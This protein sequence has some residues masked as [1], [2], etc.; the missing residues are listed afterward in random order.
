MIRAV[1][2]L[3]EVNSCSFVQPVHILH[4]VVTLG[5]FR[6]RKKKQ[7]SICFQAAWTVHCF[8]PVSHFF[9]ARQIGAFPFPLRL[10]Y[11]Q[12]LCGLY[13]AM[14]H[15]PFIIYLL[16]E[17]QMGSNRHFRIIRRIG[18]TEKCFRSSVE[19]SIKERLVILRY[20]MFFLKLVICLIYR[21]IR[22]SG[23]L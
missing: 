20:L 2:Y 15:Q 6:G 10:S 22:F 8:A 5:C 4:L 14:Y 12:V 16:F 11:D 9:L 1:S 3:S 18:N 13:V 7:R 19:N 23:R 17:L 21:N